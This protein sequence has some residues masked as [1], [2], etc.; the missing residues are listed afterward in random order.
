MD[1]TLQNRQTFFVMMAITK[2]AQKLGIPE[3]EM[4]SRLKQQ[5][6]VHNRLFR[7]YDQLHT[8]SQQYVA[9]D[10]VETLLNWEAAST[11]PVQ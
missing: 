4:Y 11:Q 6:L 9:D 10:I 7:Y 8:Q 5:G 3:Q 2:G 1:D